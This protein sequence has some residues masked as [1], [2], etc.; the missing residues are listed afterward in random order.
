[1]ISRR[2]LIA[3]ASAAGFARPAAAAGQVVVSTWGG[4]Y[5]ELLGRNVEKP[6]LEPAGIEVL[7][8]LNDQNTRKTKLIA[9]KA[10]RRGSMDVVHLS[11]TDMF[12]MNLLGMF[13]P[14]ALDKL[15]NGGNIIPSLRKPYSIPHIVSAQVI[16]YNPD[17]VK[18]PPKSFADLWNPEYQGRIAI[19]DGNYP[20]VTFAAA[21]AGG[22]SM[23]NWEPAKKML[24]DLKK[25]GPKVFPSHETLITAMQSGECWIA[26]EWLAREFMWR[27]SGVKLAHVVPE[28]GAIPVTFE[29]AV[30]KNAQHK[31]DAWAYLDAMLDAKAQ[32]G[33]ADKMGYGPTVTNAQLSPDLVSGIS[34]TEAQ[35]KAFRTPDYAYQ[36]AQLPALLDFWNKSFKG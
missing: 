19:P 14:V 33:F 10:Q 20:V 28:E 24:A 22:G 25:L 7:Q 21:I 15:K 3:A 32:L 34:F 8:D 12:Q 35:Q 16:M 13:E 1:M 17:K 30:P 2:T 26:P 6:I 11:D 18:T 5:G 29:A 9:E 4:D 36:A 23:S 31:D 27:K